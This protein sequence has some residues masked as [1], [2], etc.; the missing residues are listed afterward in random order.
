[1]PRRHVPTLLLLLVVVVAAALVVIVAV[2]RERETPPPPAATSPWYELYLTRPEPSGLM[3]W[4]RRGIETHLTRLIDSAHTSVDAAVYDFDLAEIADAL[5]RAAGRGVRVRFVTD[6]DTLGSLNLDVQ[7]AI[8]ILEAAGIRVVDDNRGAIMHHKFAVV[9]GE[10]VWT[11]SWNWTDGDTYRLDNN[12]ARI[13]SP[14]LA[15]SYT[16][17][18]ERLLAR[19]AGERRRGATPTR[20][21]AIG[22][23]GVEHYFSPDPSIVERIVG[24]I[25]G[26]ATSVQFLAFSFTDDRIGAAMRAK[27]AAGVPVRGVFEN[28]GAH[29]RFSELGRMRE[30]GLDVRTDGNRYA[31][32]HKLIVIDGR[33]AI[34]GSFNF[35]ANAAD[36]NDENI[37]MIDDPALAAAFLGEVDRVRALAAP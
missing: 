31:M 19:R 13:R 7:R 11:G 16:A 34:F 20:P 23:V 2:R 4:R 15:A 26:A 25:Q 29:T 12:A 24:R 32:H 1:M 22:G 9:D 14:E 17:E 28:V 33:T 6:T 5:A 36:V 35:S 18:M 27:H 21:L 10:T 37:V 3:L 30:A 8:D